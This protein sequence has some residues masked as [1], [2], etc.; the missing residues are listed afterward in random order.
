MIK[1]KFKNIS[2]PLTPVR[3]SIKVEKGVSVLERI[4]DNIYVLNKYKSQDYDLG[5]FNVPFA[6]LEELRTEGVPLPDPEYYIVK[7]KS[8]K[9][10]IFPV[11]SMSI[12]EVGSFERIIPEQLDGI[13]GIV[14][15]N[16]SVVGKTIV[17]ISKKERIKVVW[18]TIL[19]L[20]TQWHKPNRK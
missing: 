1:V 6:R 4:N 15:F 10:R 12:F 2:N 18:N 7:T 5:I 17:V 13:S 11:S 16:D 19:K 8:L 20:Q 3:Q 14:T 9:L